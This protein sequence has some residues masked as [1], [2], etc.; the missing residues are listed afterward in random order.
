MAFKFS[1]HIFGLCLVKESTTSDDHVVVAVDASKHAD[2]NPHHCFIV[3]PAVNIDSE[4]STL[5]STKPW[6]DTRI[7]ELPKKA[8]IELVGSRSGDLSPVAN[9]YE[10]ATVGDMRLG[11][12]RGDVGKGAWTAGEMNYLS[13]P[14]QGTQKAWVKKLG[15]KC[16]FRDNGQYRHVAD[17]FMWRGQYSASLQVKVTKGD[18]SKCL[19]L[20]SLHETDFKIAVGCVPPDEKGHPFGYWDEY[21]QLTT[22]DPTGPR[23]PDLEPKL[24]MFHVGSSSCPPVKD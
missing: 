17:A 23:E 9:E 18:S 16:R 6:F 10:P 2:C 8:K 24:N 20:R 13:L 14:S 15:R 1:V 11:T 21:L 12:V 3:V 4:S 5:E 19:T 7:F 22:K